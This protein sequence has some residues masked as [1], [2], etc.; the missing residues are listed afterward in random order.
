MLIE[1]GALFLAVSEAVEELDGEPDVVR[2]DDDLT[3]I[4]KERET[5]S[6]LALSGTR[7]IFLT[8]TDM[9]RC[10]R[11]TVLRP[12]VDPQNSTSTTS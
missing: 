9:R 12:T 7:P 11:S 5:A 6:N 10:F 2:E 3:V 4:G 8:P 1:I